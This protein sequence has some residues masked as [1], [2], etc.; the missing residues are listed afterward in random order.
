MIGDGFNNV[1]GGISGAVSNLLGSTSTTTTTGSTADSGSSKTA[2][3]VIA[4]IGVITLIIVGFVLIK[5]KR[6]A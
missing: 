6:A 1:V 3:T 2:F 4:V 5:S